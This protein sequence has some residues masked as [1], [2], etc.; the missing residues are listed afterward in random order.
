[1]REFQGV[2]KSGKHA[3]KL[4][5]HYRYL[6][7]KEGE[8]LTSDEIDAL[9]QR[10]A[11]LPSLDIFKNFITWYYNGSKGRITENGKTTKTTLENVVKL[12]LI[13][14]TRATGA[15]MSQCERDDLNEHI[16]LLGAEDVKKSKFSSDDRVFQRVIV[17][18]YLSGRAIW[19]PTG[20]S[21]GLKLLYY[22]CARPG[23]ILT[24]P[25]YQNCLRYGVSMAYL[26]C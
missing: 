26:I 25:V 9:F 15:T 21:L 22:L 1:L 3:L 14:L 5:N 11:E 10:N 8:G 16:V 24:D 6:A 17:Q 19:N 23:S 18:Y 12:T 20:F 7:A 13:T 2:K 4:N